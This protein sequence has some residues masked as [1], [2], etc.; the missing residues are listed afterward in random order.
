MKY[1]TTG[2]D[3][4]SHTT[5]L[6]VIEHDSKEKKSEVVGFTKIP[7]QGMHHGHVHNAEN[8]QK[9]VEKLLK[10]TNKLFETKIDSA[11][12]SFGSWD[13]ATQRSAMSLSVTIPTRR[14]SLATTT[15]NRIIFV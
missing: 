1:I 13:C 6:C 7:M 9:T 10:E 4:G 3:I 12:V 8:V 15:Q 5:R 14:S 11:V 2:I